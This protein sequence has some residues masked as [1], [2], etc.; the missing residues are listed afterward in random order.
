LQ[1]GDLDGLLSGASTALE[2]G[3][4][5]SVLFDP[6]GGRGIAA[7]AWPVLP[8]VHLGYAGGIGPDNITAVLQ[9]LRQICA[10][11]T[12]LWIDMES[13]VRN[14]DDKLDMARVCMVLSKAQQCILEGA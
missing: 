14:D 12:D 9:R 11:E 6:S 1:A 8:G 5:T 2:I 3:G 10:P 7:T 4:D 13:R